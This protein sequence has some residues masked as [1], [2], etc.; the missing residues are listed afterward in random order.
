MVTDEHA[1]PCVSVVIPTRDRAAMLAEAVESVLRVASQVSR[2]ARLEIVVVDDGSTDDTAAVAR[3]YPVR[4]LQGGGRGAA[5][6]R[7]LG[8]RAATGELVAFLDDDDVW[9]EGHVAPHLAV[10]RADPEV[11]LVFAQGILADTD[12]RPVFPPS[13]AAPLPSG[14]VFAYS[15]RQS[16]QWNTVVAR[17]RVLLDLGGFD[18]SLDGAEDWDLQLRLAARC[19]CAGVA[20][21]VTLY[22]Q[23]AARPK[24]FETY[25]VWYERTIGM[26]RRNARLPAR[27]RIPL[28]QRLTLTFAI[29]GWYAFR[30]AYSARAAV[31]RGQTGEALRCLGGAL[32]A[33]PL[34]SALR[35]PYFWPAAGA[36]ARAIVG[37]HLRRRGGAAPA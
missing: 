19:D 29:R 31:A 14:D 24:D 1:L 21:P 23:D 18:E 32:R 5:A 7:N 17:R 20:V 35:V 10:L 3:R 34:H 12:L 28:R 4:Y 37:A 30:F 27:S 11:A 6:A 13:P 36:V 9:L 25:R 15:L 33:S 22:R 2:E 26:V 16:V 8:I